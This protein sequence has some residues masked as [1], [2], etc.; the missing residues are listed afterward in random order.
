MYMLWSIL[1]SQNLIFISEKSDVQEF[2][3]YECGDVFKMFS[4]VT[5]LNA[6]IKLAQWCIDREIEGRKS[7]TLFRQP[8][9][10]C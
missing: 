4:Q 9:S 1:I 3:E 7:V 5:N 6:N 2:G 10:Y 8:S